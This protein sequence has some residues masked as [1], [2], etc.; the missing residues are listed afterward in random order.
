MTPKGGDLALRCLEAGA[1]NVLPKPSA[2]YPIEQLIADLLHDIRGAA[3]ADLGASRP[4]SDAPLTRVANDRGVESGTPKVIAIGASTGGTEALR[5]ILG[6]LPGNL[7][8]IVIV[9]HMPPV[10]TASFSDRLNSECVFE[11][12]EARHG[13]LVRPGLALI[14]P[15]D[16]HVK[17]AGV[18]GAYRVDVGQSPK[19]CRHRPS[20]EV[21]FQSC[22]RVAGADA[23]GV[24][25]TGMGD[26]GATGLGTIR[27]AG[28]YT[29]AQDEQSCVVFGMPRE[30]IE[31]GSVDE[32]VPLSGIPPKI[33]AF[34]Q[35]RHRSRRAS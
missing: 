5:R 6:S 23:M 19:V 18:P 8:G 14:A 26:D 22:G 3:L 10:F 15:G 21:L 27:D 9:Q 1:F 11:V 20:V 24:I 25:L 35:D 2:A 13:D 28:G 30:A 31:R 16:F 34:V 32:V 7:P 17:L 33:V 4:A 29:I 12:R